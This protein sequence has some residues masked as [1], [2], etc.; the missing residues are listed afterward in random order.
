MDGREKEHR[1]GDIEPIR[2]RRPFPL[3]IILWVTLLWILLGW[4]RFAAAIR[5]RDLI[6]SLVSP[7]LD[8]Y[9]IAAGL[10]WGLAGLPE[11]WGLVTRAPWTPM[12]IKITAV[13]YPG[14]YWFERLFLWQD[15]DDGSNWL[16]MLLL[17]ILWLVLTFG[18]LKM[19]RV[20]QF[21]NKDITIRKRIR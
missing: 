13:L 6:L 19:K 2:G 18:A 8:L 17:T 21:F 16:F 15:G 5:S 20:Q 1:Q 9:L 14:L 11:V 12:L 10:I 3:T 7:G 4:L